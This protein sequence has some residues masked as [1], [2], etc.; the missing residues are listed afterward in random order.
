MDDIEY[1][2]INDGV[3][4]LHNGHIGYLYKDILKCNDSILKKNS[5]INLKDHN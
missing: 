3:K 2:H 5:S 1:T 4:I